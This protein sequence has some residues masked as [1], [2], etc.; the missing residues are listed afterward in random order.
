MMR[1]ICYLLTAGL[2]LL[3]AGR[4]EA[5]TLI[6][7]PA[8]QMSL[9]EA[10]AV[11]EAQSGL[12][13]AYNEQLTDPSRQVATPSGKTV[14][15]TLDIIFAGSE[16]EAL[17]KGTMI[18]VIK[19]HGQT[20][21]RV[22]GTIRDKVGPV[23]GAVITCGANA[24]MTDLD[25][26]FSITA[27]PGE[28]LVVSMLGYKEASYVVGRTAEGIEIVLADDSE[29][30]EESVV[31]GYGTMQRRDI[32]SSIATYKPS[33]EGERDF[34]SPDAMI[35]GRVAGVNIAAASGTPG[36]KTRVSIRGVGSITAG[37]EPLYVVDGVP[38]SNTSG[39][40]GAYGG[41][42]LSALSDI[43]PADIE[44]IQVL[45]DAA[46]AA[47]Y[48]SRGTNGVIIITTRKGAKGKPKFSANANYGLSYLQNLDKLR[49]A[50]ADLYLEVQNE[51]IDNYNKQTGSAIARLENPFPGKPQF[52][53]LD[54][55]FRV[56]QSW[57]AGMS[58]SGGGE[59]SDYYLSASVKQNQGVGI[60]S[61]YEKYGVK[62]NLNTQ[63]TSWLKLG[64]AINLSYT[65][66]NRVPDG[67]IGT[68]MLTHGLEHR[69]WDTPF[70][71]DGSYT[72]INADLLH[73]NLLQAIN[74]QKV[75]NKSYRVYGN[76]YALFDLL[77]GLTFKTSFGGDFMSAEDHVYYSK[78]HMYGNS[79]GVLT[80]SRRNFTSII[81][82][83]IL[84]YKH[85]F[86]GLNLDAML[87]HS[88]QM[89]NNSTAMQKG[90][91]FPDKEFD[92]N[93]VAAEITDYT[94]GLSTWALQSFML[95]TTLNYRNRYLATVNARLDGSSKF[96]S[97]FN[98]RYGF[99]PSVSLGW[100]L[101]EEPF[102]NWSGTM[103]KLRASYGATGNQG[104]IGNYAWR[105]LIN[106]GYNYNGK[107][108]YAVMQ[109]GN[110]NLQW[111]TAHQYDVGVD[112]SFFQGA[113][114]FTADAFIKNTENLLYDTPISATKGYTQLTSNIGT[115]QNK[116]LE[117]SVGGN[118]GKGDF[119]WKGDFN[120][121]FVKNRLTSLI[122]DNEILKT[123]DY[124]ALKVGEEI[125]SFY[126]IKM[127]G[128]YQSDEEVP[129]YQYEHY[130]VR[131]GDVI[132]DDVNKD[133]DIKEE[134]DAQF[135][136]SANPKFTGGLS[137][138]FTWKGF[139]ANIFFTFSYGAKL[140]EYWTGGLRLGNGNW[141][142]QESEA[143][144][145]WTGPGTS[146]TVPRAIYGYTWNSTMFKN[147]RFL[148]DASYIRLKTV[149]LGY[150]LPK[151]LT[152]RIGIE[153]LRVYFQ[154]DN[155][156]HY[157]PFRFLDPEVNT[158]MT[159]TKMGLDCMWIPQPTSF[160]IGVNLK[161]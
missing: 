129:A 132:Y 28:T 82:D 34:I 139:D 14:Q 51:A 157:S 92:V 46:S 160:S 40:T 84:T 126:M 69:P 152:R 86:G 144:S 134:D 91:G 57:Q 7:F 115:M 149:Q 110:E 6:R 158:S 113:L 94:T 109:P 73:Y 85:A 150:T 36:G 19:S 45:K 29:M 9:R 63:L 8:E 23:A 22:S 48:G 135:V 122:G 99:F 52:S 106:A 155:V 130:G 54:M 98:H 41:E 102:W 62:S 11:I 97:D 142:A 145:R 108:G 107:N 128:I 24:S 5:Q 61:L 58:V 56:A 120:I 127:L 76:A 68:S 133:G 137:N 1:R 116:G 93:S 33:E 119:H 71:G 47:I 147:T 146:N 13:I 67:S 4:A 65:N 156:W 70:K 21:Q 60:G 74:E 66:A 59:Q 88:F 32:T 12:S 151:R 80:D 104:G 114:S 42:S 112:L 27:A 30:L 75:Y 38:M 3:V 49:V 118:L 10:L 53:W 153:K 17:V 117:F 72:I 159:A 123:D 111:E 50:D 143:L 101:S 148:H 55:V 140:Y 18:L 15:E 77:P 79:A 121:S 37:N 95:R 35:Q 138:S 25:G 2:L 100:N 16:N 90:Q 26:K 44:S 83:N 136:G 43:N 89:D 39:D 105:T 131:A 20:P 103:A 96:A 64:A 125:G 154:G 87:G 31:V 161:L 141:P 81:V 78:D 124:H